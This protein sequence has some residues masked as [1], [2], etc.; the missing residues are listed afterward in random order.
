[1]GEQITYKY[2]EQVDLPPLPEEMIKEMY[3]SIDNCKNIFYDPKHQWYQSFL[4]SKPL[5]DFT[6]QLFKF[7]HLAIVQVIQKG[8][9]IHID[10]GRTEAFNYIIETGGVNAT[11]AFYKR[12]DFYFDENN[13]LR[14]NKLDYEMS[15]QICIPEKKWH[16]IKVDIPH[17]VKNIETK[18]ISLSVYAYKHK[19]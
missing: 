7:E 12:D 17:N 1:M 15:E 6:K 18:R 19:K 2:Y 8:L 3:W 16:K 14:P 5:A 4:V 9:P 13:K 11:T 10:F